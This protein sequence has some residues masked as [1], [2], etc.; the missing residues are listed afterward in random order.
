[1]RYHGKKYDL[2]IIPVCSLIASG[3]HFPDPYAKI[4]LILTLSSLT[5]PVIAGWSCAFRNKESGTFSLNPVTR[6]RSQKEAK[7]NEIEM[8]MIK[9]TIILLVFSMI[10]VFVGFLF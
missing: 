1:M 8:L 3:F 6:W 7:L 5:L 4:S 10:S 2:V 9:I